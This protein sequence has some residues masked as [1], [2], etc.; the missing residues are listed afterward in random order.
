V[1]KDTVSCYRMQ[2][3]TNDARCAPCS[4]C[5]HEM[6]LMLRNWDFF[7]F[8]SVITKNAYG[9]VIAVAKK[10]CMYAV[11]F[12]MMLAG[13]EPVRVKLHA[14]LECGYMSDTRVL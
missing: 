12:C 3:E 9:A 11:P 8:T 2:R 5:V 14:R 13:G 1:V 6:L 10:E 7:V 4:A